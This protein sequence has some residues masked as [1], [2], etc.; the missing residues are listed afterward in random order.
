[1]LLTIPQKLIY[2]ISLS[3]QVITLAAIY[4]VTS[5]IG[6]TQ[7]SLLITQQTFI[8]F[9][10]SIHQI[11]STLKEVIAEK[12][13]VDV[14]TVSDNT[15]NKIILP[16]IFIVSIVVLVYFGKNDGTDIGD[17]VSFPK[18]LGEINYKFEDLSSRLKWIERRIQES[19]ESILKEMSDREIIFFKENPL[20]KK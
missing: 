14:V 3:I 15:N 11:D 2:G 13:L 18:S 16:A 8:E 5:D 10:N 12:K 1:M 20:N 7:Q 17:F 9:Q 4:Q 6:A 19:N